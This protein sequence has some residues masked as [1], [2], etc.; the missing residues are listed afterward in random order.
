[1]RF[2]KEVSSLADWP[3]R[4]LS[5]KVVG[6]ANDLSKVQKSMLFWKHKNVNTTSFELLHTQNFLVR[7]AQDGMQHFCVRHF[8]Q[9][10]RTAHSTALTQNNSTITSMQFPSTRTPSATPLFGQIAQQSLTKRSKD[11]PICFADGHLSSHEC[12]AGTAVVSKLQRLC[13]APR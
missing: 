5:Q 4:A 8:G 12:G 10:L 7:E 11:S 13:R 9:N 2:R 3:S 1:M 6:M